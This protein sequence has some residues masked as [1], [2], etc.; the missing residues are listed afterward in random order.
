[1]IDDVEKKELSYDDYL[2]MVKEQIE[3]DKLMYDLD[4]TGERTLNNIVNI[5]ADVYSSED[6]G[7]RINNNFKSVS[8]VKSQFVKLH[9]GHIEWVIKNLKENRAR[10]TNMNAYITSAL[11]NALNQMDDYYQNEFNSTYGQ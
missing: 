10:I 2:E 9:S 1:M 3:Y 5:M 4:I 8:I 7:Y 6:G 11:W